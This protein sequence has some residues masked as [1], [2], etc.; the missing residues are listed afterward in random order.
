MKSLKCL[1]TI[2]IPTFVS[3]N[4]DFL[5]WYRALTYAKNH[6][7]A[8]EVN[9]LKK[10]L[11]TLFQLYKAEFHSYHIIFKWIIKHLLMW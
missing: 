1:P 7:G 9:S 11:F 4:P 6:S 2:A 5:H 8:F 3:Q 10:Y